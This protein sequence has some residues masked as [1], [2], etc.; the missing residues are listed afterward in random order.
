MGLYVFRMLLMVQWYL[1]ITMKARIE[2][3]QPWLNIYRLSNIKWL[4]FLIYMWF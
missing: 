2:M 4:R 3:F 1:Y